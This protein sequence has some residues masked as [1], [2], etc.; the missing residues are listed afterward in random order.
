MKNETLGVPLGGG[1]FCIRGSPRRGRLVALSVVLV[2]SGYHFGS[3]FDP[4]DV[5]YI[6]SVRRVAG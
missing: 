2:S 3:K 1:R 5:L 6:L 4:A